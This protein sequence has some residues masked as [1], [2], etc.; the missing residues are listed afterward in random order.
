MLMSSKALAAV[1]L[2][3]IAG[4]GARWGVATQI[5]ADWALLIVNV[6]GC[7]IIGWATARHRRSQLPR[8]GPA[9][10]ARVSRGGSDRSPWLTA[11]FCGALTSM[12]ALALQLAQHLTDGRAAAAGAWLGLTVIACTTAFVM[13][14]LTVL[15]L[16]RQP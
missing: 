8:L 7:A 6:A 16:S 4:A 10:A 14:R 9:A 13:S 2:A 12:S 1:A 5:G 15:T 11:G 3:G